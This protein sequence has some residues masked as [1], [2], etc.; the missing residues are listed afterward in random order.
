M[1]DFYLGQTRP[2]FRFKSMTSGSINYL[3]NEKS[4]E[5]EHGI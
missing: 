3:N 5:C 4:L 1:M 2:L